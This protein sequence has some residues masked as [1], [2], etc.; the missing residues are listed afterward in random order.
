MK[1]IHLKKTKKT[2]P[3][4]LEYKNYSML[5]LL[6][7]LSALI[8]VLVLCS[9]LWFVYTYIYKTITQAEYILIQETDPGVKPI[10][11]KLYEKVSSAWEQKTTE[12]NI[13]KSSNPFDKASDGT[14]SSL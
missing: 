4:G 5:R 7:A 6:N 3:K 2:L 12:K 9:T 13:E 1:N 14:S 11:F 8:I 10:N